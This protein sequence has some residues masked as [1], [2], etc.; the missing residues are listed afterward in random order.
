M[1]LRVVH[2]TATA[3]GAPW[4]I[5]LAREQK[6][7]GHDVEVIIPS[8]DGTIAPALAREGIRC[9]TAALDVLVGPR[10]VDRVR[11]IARLVRLLR[12]LRPDVVHSHIINSVITARIASWIADVP[13]RLAGNASPLTLE[14]E[15]LRTL[16]VGTAFCD[17]HTIASCSYTRE[18]FRRY[19]I[20]ESQCATVYYAPDHIPFDPALADGA[21][22]RRE[23]GIDEGT[24]LVGMVAYFY[25]PSNSVAVL[26]PRFARRG[27]KG[28]DVLLR[29]MPVV[30]AVAPNATLVLVGG[31]WGAEGVAYMAEMKTLARQL[32]VEHAV[33]F[34]GERTDIADVLAALDVSVQASL[35]D[36]LGGTLESLLMARPL[37]VSDIRGFADAVLADETGVVVPPDD[38]AAL[39]AGITRLLNDRDL[40]RRLGENGR[41][42]MLERFTAARAA[43]D[44][45]ELLSHHAERADAHY[46]AGTTLWRAC[47]M[48]FRLRPVL[49]QVK[50]ILQPDGP[51]RFPRIPRMIR[52]KSAIR[53]FVKPALAAGDGKRIV[54]VVGA[55]EGNDW[56][57]TLCRDLVRRGYDVAAVIDAQRGDLGE[58]LTK[59]GIRHHTVA[60]TFGLRFDRARIVTYPIG[61]PIAAIRL[62]GVL[63]HER[64]DIVHSH[65]FSTVVVARIAAALA[66]VR[67]VAGI[68]GPRHLDAPLTRTVD[69]LTW[70][71]DD[72]TLAGCRYTED[73]YRTLGANETRLGTVYYGAD[74][75]RF[76]PAR[77]DGAAARRDLDVP[78]GAPLVT[79][80]AQF[81]APTRGVQAPR[82][83]R[84]LGAKGQHDLIAAA[85]IIARR[86]PDARFVLAGGGV[87]ARGDAYR[88]MLAEQCRRDDLLRDRV[89]FTGY[90]ADVPSLLAASDVSVQCSLTEN[91][92]GT[93]E[94]LLMERPVVATRVGGM[95]ESVRDGETGLL[96]PPSD[97]EALAAA[98]LHLLDHR[99]EALAFG[100]A[101]RR[102]MLERFTSDRTIDDIDAVYRR[103]VPEWARTAA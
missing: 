46:R 45:E 79:L 69:R 81:Y 93:I 95:P 74:A 65:I 72:A 15:L 60:L 22:V 18:L 11:L 48:P 54:Q 24:P 28:H 59:A 84:S 92:G 19:G 43:S 16:E 98:I 76:N 31:G 34:T 58:R 88:G 14:S 78:Q 36:N 94:S 6:K 80:V 35:I 30:R 26:G 66:R 29:A 37:V 9:H 23:L 82:H 32:G 41:R 49:R 42:R 90:H 3:N 70:W 97:P 10:S 8:L 99:D 4:M 17:T 55:W 12:R 101:G 44:L 85:R 96:V 100:R 7:L 102:L 53:S 50:A 75:A 71:L 39:A 62:A 73:R 33:I 64:A 56:F 21:R 57:V 77:A 47:V 40:A 87:T 103:L 68:A 52:V 51:T 67:H 89:I 86:R 27:L 5:A 1:P 25:A 83:T 38:P 2:L 20:P 63:R 91:L 61:I 13:V